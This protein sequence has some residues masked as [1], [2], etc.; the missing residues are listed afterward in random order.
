M[1]Q[2]QQVEE[3]VCLVARM[4]RSTIARKLR[5]FR[6]GFPV[7]FTPSFIETTDLERLR[8]IFLA[9]CLQARQMPEL[10]DDDDTSVMAEHVA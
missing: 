9:L 2:S 5:D 10:E 3:L 6:G 8:H 4:D 7:D 1:W